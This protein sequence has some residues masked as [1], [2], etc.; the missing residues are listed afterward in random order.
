MKKGLFGPQFEDA[1]YH[2]VEGNREGPGHIVSSVRK[3]GRGD[4]QDG[5]RENTQVLINILLITN[6]KDFKSI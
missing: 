2:D 1:V 4:R 5:E 6:V 3:G